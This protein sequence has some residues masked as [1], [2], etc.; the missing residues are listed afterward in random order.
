MKLLFDENLSRH[1]VQ[2]LSDIF[3]ES[4]H[5]AA[6]GLLRSSD[7]QIWE[8]AKT[9]GFTIITADG[10]FYEIAVAQGSPPKLIWLR[11]CD[12]PTRDA[13]RLIRSQSVRIAEFLEDQDRSVLI[14]KR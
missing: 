2:R 1:L 12:Y 9:G 5:V 4:Q 14:L 7:R 10:D 8:Y 13:E 6:V 3:P 11:G